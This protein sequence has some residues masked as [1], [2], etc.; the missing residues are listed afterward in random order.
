MHSYPGQ[1]PVSTIKCLRRFT[2]I[3][4]LSLFCSQL[5]AEVRVRPDS[6]AQ[7]VIGAGLDNFYRVAP[8][9]YR[10]EQP[11]RAAF[12]QLAAYG[13]SG[14]LNRNGGYIFLSRRRKRYAS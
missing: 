5:N 9:L 6:W 14:I 12:E 1:S 10:S 2:L 4:L 7:P 11:D 3:V 13:I 8:N